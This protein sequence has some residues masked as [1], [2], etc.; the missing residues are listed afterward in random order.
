MSTIDEAPKWAFP[1]VRYLVEDKIGEY[2]YSYQLRAYEDKI[3]LLQNSLAEKQ[4]EVE[5]LTHELS[6]MSSQIADLNM[7]KIH[8]IDGIKQ[9]FTRINESISQEALGLIKVVIK[10]IIMRELSVND[11][12]IKGMLDNILSNI[13]ADENIQVEVSASDY[14]VLEQAEFKNPYKIVINTHLNPGDIIVTCQTGGVMLK[15]DEAIN[16]VLGK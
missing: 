8:T 7:Q 12:A 13:T 6:E 9:S 16:S 10:K 11:Q 4:S 2:N 14:P 3:N 1:D 5:R 15:I